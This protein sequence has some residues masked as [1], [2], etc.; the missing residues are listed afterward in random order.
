MMMQLL[1]NPTVYL[2]FKVDTIKFSISGRTILGY[3]M[4]LTL[5][6]GD[7]DSLALKFEKRGR[8][9]NGQGA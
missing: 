7:I 8:C 9:K 2:P 1:G 4:G 3:S 6:P 5:D